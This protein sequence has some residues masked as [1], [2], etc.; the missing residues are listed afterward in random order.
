LNTSG[1]SFGGLATGIDSSKIIEGLTKIGQ[2]RIDS[3]NAR[4]QQ[5][6]DRQGT[7]VSLQT[8]LAGLQ[9]QANKL[10][11]S[12]GSAFDARSVSLTDDKVATA[13]AG[14]A[15]IPGIYH[16]TVGSVARAHQVA[17]AGFVD[18][19][20]RIKE[21]TL[22]V[23]AGSGPVINVTI[24]S[25]NNTLQGLADA[26]NNAN[27]EV[28][29]AIINDGS[30]TPYRLLLTSSKTGTAGAIQVTNNL[31]SGTGAVIDPTAFTVQAAT[32]AQVTLGSG[33]GAITVTSSTNT[34]NTLIPGISLDL[35]QANPGTPLTLTVANDTGGAQTAVKD[36]VNSF[37]DVIDFV[38]ES[39]KFDKESQTAGALIGDRDITELQNALTQAITAVVPGLSSGANRLSTVGVT[40]GNDGKLTLDEEK[41]SQAVKGGT[42]LAD[43]KRLFGM[44]GT[45]DNPAVQ[46]GIAT[47]KTQPS[48]AS[49][50]VVN[51]VSQATRA[52]VS[53]STAINGTVTLSPPNNLLSLRLNGLVASGI[54][55]APGTY[56]PD[57]V[58]A[59]LQQAI[60]TNPVLN[61]NRVSVEVGSGGKLTLTSQMYGSSSRISFEGGSALA[62][63]GFTGTESG[64]GTNV[65]GEF[66]VNG[67][68]EAAT[69]SGQTL[70]GKAG[71]ANTD[72][73]MVRATGTDPTTAN[74]TVTQGLAGRL[75]AVLGK[76]LDS[77]TGKFK[78]IYDRFTREIEQYDKQITRQNSLL[79]EKKTEL[80]LR[81]AQ[82]ESA[83]NS[84]RG[85]GAS[86][87]ALIPKTT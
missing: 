11:R 7:F 35:K 79:T 38:R 83:V 66:V 26:I 41:L 47:S 44:T 55:L 1:L 34:V 53:G 81:F 51:I 54:E 50:Y 12:A 17:S 64:S 80:T 73:L 14:T 56:S 82:M 24:D 85:V 30:A 69:G 3:L 27:G 13:T 29:A 76:F 58:A 32:D 59:L 18:P 39:T 43:L 62:L 23:Q 57:E 4:K 20:T 21:G 8:K 37:N 31:T 61:G 40:L 19:A 68:V 15:A 75:N 63:L 70:T 67:K 33:A 9:L 52:T 6:I 60:N 49:S 25:R 86:L 74:V 87:T 65:L 72:G 28:R 22:S 48:S 78:T 45:S 46:F 77:S 71:N 5:A 16:L 84:L 42:A 10:A 2:Q 36:L